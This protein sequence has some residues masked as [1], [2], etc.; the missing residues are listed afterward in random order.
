M[1]ES[2]QGTLVRGMGG[3]YTVRTASGEEYVLRAKKK[4]RREHMTPLVGDRVVFSPGEIS[5]EH[6]WI[7]E[8]LPR[9]NHYVRPPVANVTLMCITVSPVPE[10]D[11]LLVD[12]LLIHAFMQGLS[13]V[14]L[15]N[16]NDLDGGRTAEALACAYGKAG[17]GVYSVSAR[18]GDGLAALKERLR[19]ENACFSGQSG[20]GKSSLLNALFSVRAETGGISERIARGKNTT[21][22]T[23]LF[24]ADGCRVFDT[25]GFSLL[26]ITEPMEPVSLQ[27]WYPEMAGLKDKCRFEG[28]CHVSEPGCAVREAAERGQMDSGRY[29]RYR[30][31]MEN[32]RETWKNRYR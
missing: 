13:P 24:E 11:C 25:P 31:L 2:N 32:A 9:T 5:D 12:K 16:K 20:V 8:I 22:H 21:R 4:F 6:G 29:I 30:I 1:K 28:C 18:T 19:G 26:E 15:V 14:L 7:E 17:I 23:E 27:N 10:P 3:L